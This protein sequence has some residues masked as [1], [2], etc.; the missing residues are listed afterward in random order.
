MP[1][2][3]ADEEQERQNHLPTVPETDLPVKRHIAVVALCGLIFLASCN[4]FHVIGT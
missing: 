4:A 3:G 2:S 1:T